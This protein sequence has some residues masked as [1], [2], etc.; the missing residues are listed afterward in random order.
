MRLRGIGN[1][2]SKINL[3]RL[4]FKYYRRAT[5]P[6]LGEG[7]RL[8]PPRVILSGAKRNRTAQQR[9][10]QRRRDLEGGKD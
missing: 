8:Q 4:G 9:R 1:L 6:V 7:F 3:I 2:Y 10:A 5:F